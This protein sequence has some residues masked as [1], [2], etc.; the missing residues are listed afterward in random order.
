MKRKIFAILSWIFTAILI[1]YVVVAGVVASHNDEHVCGGVQI[2]VEDADEVSYITPLDVYNY[3]Q[4]LHIVPTGKSVS[5]VRLQLIEDALT[6]HPLVDSVECFTSADGEILI[7]LT[8]RR[9]L[10]HVITP[11]TNYFVAT[12]HRTMPPF[13]SLT[14]PVL[15]VKGIVDEVYACQH[16]STLAEWLQ[17]NEYWTAHLSYIQMSD[18]NNLSLLLKNDSTR[19]LFGTLSDFPSKFNRLQKWYEN[20]PIQPD[21]QP[22]RELDVRFAGQV[23]GRHQ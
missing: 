17:G 5:D 4:H 23:I 9:P 19:I 16:L 8:Q 11:D 10:L 12:D 21:Y 2:I 14:T 6:H 13:P 18:T 15:Q 7:H 20:I 1:V 22:Y 3:L